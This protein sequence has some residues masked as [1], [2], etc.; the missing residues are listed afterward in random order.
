MIC[1]RQRPRRACAIRMPN[2]LAEKRTVLFDEHPSQTPKGDMRIVSA[3]RLPILDASGEVRYLV[4]VIDDLTS[5]KHAEAR[6]AH[7]AH[8]DILTGLPNRAAFN[9]CLEAT[10]ESSKKKR[11]PF[12]VMALDMSRIKEINDVFGY[13]TGDQVLCELAQRL[14]NAAEGA[15]IARLGG[16]EFAI[17]AHEGEQPMTA[18]QIAQRVHAALSEEMVI[19]GRSVQSGVTIGIAIYP[20]D[21]EDAATLVAN[22]N[23]ALHRAKTND[24]GTYRFFEADMD[25]QLR[26]RRAL[27][28]DLSAAIENGELSLHYQ[29]QARVD[30]QIF[31]FEALVR[32]NHPIRGQVPPST[33]IPLAEDSALIVP[34]GEWILREACREAASWPKPLN[35]A[36][37]LSPIQFRHGDLAALVSTVLE[38]TGLAPQRLELEITEGVLIGDY[39]RALTI[40]RRLKA[41]GARIA[42]DDFGTGYSSLSYLQAFPF[43]KIKIDRT[44]VS[45]LESNPQSGT[46]VRAVIGLARG[47]A[48]P[49]IAEGVETSA[50]L[51]ILAN[52]GCDEVQG[53]LIGRPEPIDSYASLVGRPIPLKRR[54][55]RIEA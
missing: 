34:I 26:D 42:M 8:H 31:G 20:Q 21:G 11:S 39:S 44:F 40:L 51:N 19:D 28:Q 54:S 41:L 5:R 3:I 17:V 2:A 9:N 36:V 7:L 22:A 33:F 37:N 16:D 13:S 48:V 53:Y 24:R 49:V 52:E 10:L 14:Q 43:D 50:Q 38:E 32:W 47:F 35:I 12:V 18:E 15:F 25:R 45:N 23:A 46:I 27:Q 6:I 29:P 55:D 30:G 4:S 1:F